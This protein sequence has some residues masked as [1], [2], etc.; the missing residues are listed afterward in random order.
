MTKEKIHEICEYYRIDNYTINDDLSIDVNDDV[1]L[2]HMNLEKIPLNFNRVS[3]Y[4]DCSD[5]NLISL[6][7][8]PPY[9]GSHFLCDVNELSSL[10]KAPKH[11]NGNFLCY[12]NKLISLQY[13]PHYID[14]DFFL[15]NNNIRSFQYFPQVKDKI[16]LYD[17]PIQEL[18][19]LFKDKNHI[20][21]FNELDI[22]QN[23]GDTVI[24][25][26]LN[27]FL[28]DIGK[29]EV[30]EKKVKNYKVK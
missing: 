16:E 17:N 5:N 30:N 14:G 4:F 28:T 11:I 1:I 9:I 27:Y 10:K 21:Y 2:H 12:S 24:L 20:N 26:R 6:E 15:L 25:D 8:C 13:S 22:I 18:W 23:D 3:G 7:G 29:K 19:D